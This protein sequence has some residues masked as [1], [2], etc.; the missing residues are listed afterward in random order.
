MC[1][2]KIDPNP[3][4]SVN[5]FYFQTNR[6][7]VIINIK[8]KIKQRRNLPVQERNTTVE[9]TS[10]ST[11]NSSKTHKKKIQQNKERQRIN[12]LKADFASQYPVCI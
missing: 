12:L 3:V 9:C 10:H 11:N 8:K 7:S 6:W 2:C 5:A 1:I 4:I